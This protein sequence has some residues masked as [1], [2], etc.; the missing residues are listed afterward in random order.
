MYLEDSQHRDPN[1][2]E[3][4]SDRAL[5]LKSPVAV[6][7]SQLRSVDLHSNQRADE[8]G[9]GQQQQHVY[10]FLLRLG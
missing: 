7:I 2:V 1:V 9:Q 6:L 3:V 5:V 4:L 10:E 8:D